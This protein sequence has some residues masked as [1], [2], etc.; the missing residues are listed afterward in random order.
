MNEANAGHQIVVMGVSGSGKSTIGALI[1]DA[2]GAAFI[3]GDSLHPMENV[4]KMAAGKPLTDTDR[5]PWLAQVGQEL[6]GAVATGLVVAYS[7]LKRSYRT[8]ILADAPAA[9]FIHLDGTSEVL[10]TRMEGRSD[11]FMPPALLE[12]QLATL[13]R[14]EPEEPGFRT[15]I[16]RPVQEIVDAA[17]AGLAVQPAPSS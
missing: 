17:L 3:D 15:D 10:S 12:S 9:M 7:A 16:D 11:H 5:W 4:A 1:A 14:L 2:L 13:E 8:A 6:R